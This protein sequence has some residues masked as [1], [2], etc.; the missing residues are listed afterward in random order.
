VNGAN[1]QTVV[2]WPTG[3]G[4]GGNNAICGMHAPPVKLPALT[5]GSDNQPVLYEVSNKH[6]KVTCEACLAHLPRQNGC[7]GSNVILSDDVTPFS[8]KPTP[9]CP[10]HRRRLIYTGWSIDGR[11]YYTCPLAKESK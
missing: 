4:A 2:H 5:L 11:R 8:E 3:S 6:E 9:L 10:R 7:S 1:I